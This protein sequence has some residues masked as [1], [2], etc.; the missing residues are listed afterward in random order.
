MKK[1]CKLISKPQ[2][3]LFGVFSVT[4]FTLISKCLGLV[5]EMVLASS[6]GTS[7]HLDCVIVAMEPSVQLGMIITTALS[8]VML[9]IYIDKKIRNP[10]II[11]EYSTSVLFASTFSLTLFGI[12]LFSFSREVASFFAPK[13]SAE[14]ILYTSKMIRYLSPLPLFI[15]LN[16]IMGTILRAERK[17]FQQAIVQVIFNLITIPLIMIFSAYL[18]ETSYVLSWFL[19]TVSMSIIYFLLTKN[20]I[21]FRL[22]KNIIF[23]NDI[24]ETYKLS[25]PLIFGNGVGS[26]N[27]IVDKAF[28]SSL[29]VGSISSLRYSQ[30]LLTIFNSIFVTSFFST[31]YTKISEMVVNSEFDKLELF[32]RKINKKVLG[33]IIPIT[34][35]IIL[36]ADKII[37]ILFQRGDFNETSTNMVSVALIS[38]I[39]ITLTASYYTLSMNVLVILKKTRITMIVSLFS[40][41]INTVLDYLFLN[42]GHAGIALSTTFVAFVNTIYL[43]MILRK[44]TGISIFKFKDLCKSSWSSIIACIF[45]WILKGHIN[46]NIFAIVVSIVFFILFLSN[47]IISIKE[48]IKNK[49]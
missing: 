26:I 48:I 2:S 29:S 19:G 43:L 28:A 18:G 13:F 40:L 46:D 41:F 17:F 23:G 45:F 4:F 34:F 32:L 30:N 15:G 6:F 21:S 37:Q 12:F 49:K 31:A 33:V 14:K 9:P 42:L 10:K 20:Y 1:I 24:R 5:R 11:K 35:W 25:L 8:T 7:W 36:T 16:T 3:I 27:Q 44:T 38:Y 22:N 47:N 39:L